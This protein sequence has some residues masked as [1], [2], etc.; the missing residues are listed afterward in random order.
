MY[1]FILSGVSAAF[2]EDGVSELSA[3]GASAGLVALGLVHIVEVLQGV[4]DHACDVDFLNRAR[5]NVVHRV[6][7]HHLIDLFSPLSSFTLTHLDLARVL[8]LNL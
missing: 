8:I 6:V 5:S 3:A 2:D 7:Y 4:R 1:M